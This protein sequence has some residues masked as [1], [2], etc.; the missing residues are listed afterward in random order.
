MKSEG[1]IRHKIKQ[2]RFRYLKRFIQESLD[3][4]PENCAHNAPLDG[5][6]DE[7]V[8]VCFAQIDPVSRRGVVCD[9]RFGGCD[10]AS[11]CAM[12]TPAR[13]KSDVKAAFYADLDGMTFPE[14]AYN[15][16]DMAALLWVLADEGVDVP[17][18]DPHEFD[19]SDPVPPAPQDAHPPVEDAA[20]VPAT[21]V[22]VFDDPQPQ[23]EPPIRQPSFIDRLMGRVPS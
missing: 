19:L 18:P 8:R 2:V 9:D 1:A 10:R 11:A 3:R 23:P 14:I 12:F 13:T 15:Y 4:K 21:V 7:A 20:T 5:S 22:T 6:G 16:P 17:P